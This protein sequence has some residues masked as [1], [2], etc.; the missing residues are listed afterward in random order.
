MKGEVMGWRLDSMRRSVE[1]FIFLF[2]RITF[3]S[4]FPVILT[5]CISEFVLYL[6]CHFVLSQLRLSVLVFIL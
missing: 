3:S 2:T 5:L 1:S 4:S 6:F